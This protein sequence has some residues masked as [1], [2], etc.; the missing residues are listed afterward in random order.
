MEKVHQLSHLYLVTVYSL[1]PGVQVWYAY[2]CVTQRPRRTLIS[3][4]DA[5]TNEPAN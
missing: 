1:R 4:C 5:S 2:N 3:L